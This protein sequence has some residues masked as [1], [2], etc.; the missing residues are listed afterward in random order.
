MTTPTVSILIPNYNNGPSS[1]LDRQR[2]F[3]SDLLTSLR[4]TLEHDPTPVEIIIADDG[5]TD[6]SL[7]TA[8]QWSRKQW[9]QG[10][11]EKHPFCRLIELEHCGVLSVVAN[12][13]TSEAQGDIIVRLDG[14]IVVHTDN[15]ASELKRI[16]DSAPPRVGIIGPKQLAPDGSIHAFGDWMLHPRG[17]HH[18]AQG[19][20]AD[21]ITRA[22]EVDHVMGCF[23][24]FTREV[25]NAVGEYDENF[26]RGQ[27]VDYTVRARLAG[28]TVWAVPTIEFS[29]YHSMRDKRTNVADTDD[30]LN[31]TRRRFQ[32]K[33]GFDRIVPDLDVVAKKYAGTPLLWNAAVFGPSTHTN[34]PQMSQQELME[35]TR[36]GSYQR[37]ENVQAL[38]SAQLSVIEQTIGVQSQPVEH[39]VQVGSGD[40]LLC[41]MLAQKGF[42]MT[43]VDRDAQLIALAQA[44]T[45][46]ATYNETPPTFA[47]QDDRT[48]P[49]DDQCADVVLLL[50]VLESH[51]NPVGLL[52]DVHRIMRP[53][54]VAIVLTGKRPTPLDTDMPHVHRYRPHEL[55][56]QLHSMA[57]FAV[58]EPR[59]WDTPIGML[60]LLRRVRN[61]AKA[62]EPKPAGTR[63]P[64]AAG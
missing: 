60:Q 45:E 33:W 15:W 52:K 41:H 5:S 39:I 10:N 58:E 3:L 9:S 56:G 55:K 28:Y 31:T 32:E 8:R 50:N 44:V 48:L 42:R 35:K 7:E 24:C 6:E 1:A 40:G 59:P 11:R 57:L 23:Y 2:D 30:G 19:V 20:N 13:L 62:A 36:W 34:A 29:H 51:P 12:R 53:G 17:Y 54:G 14:D 47:H 63:A 38:V 25:W 43:G 22:M 27:T 26:L 61:P 18:V 49:V 21:A 64:V 4:S 16:F 46:R 37:N